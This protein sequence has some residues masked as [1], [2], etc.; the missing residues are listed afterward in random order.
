MSST[1]RIIPWRLKSMLGLAVAAGLIVDLGVD[2]KLAL[3]II[4]CFLIF[5]PIRPA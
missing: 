2:L 3:L 1:F 5:R 4:P